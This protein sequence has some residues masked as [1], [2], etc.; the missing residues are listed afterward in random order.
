MQSR[1]IESSI[2]QPEAELIARGNVG[3]IEMLIID[4]EAFRIINLHDAKGECGVDLSGVVGLIFTNGVGQFSARV[5]GAVEHIN[6][7]VS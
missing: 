4:E 1:V 7:R 2:R 3:G 5:V 6:E